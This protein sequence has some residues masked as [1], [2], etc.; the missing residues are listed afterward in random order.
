MEKLYQIYLKGRYDLIVLDTP[1]TR[2]ALDFLEA[3]NRVRTFFDRSISQWFLKPY[4]AMSKLGLNFFNRSAYV[5]LK[6]VERITGAEFLHDVSE[7]VTGLADAFD[8]FRSRAEEV[9]R[10]LQGESTSFLLITGTELA[11]IEEATF[12]YDQLR[13]GHLPFGGIIVN[14][15]HSFGQEYSGPSSY[16]DSVGGSGQ[17]PDPLPSF[18]EKERSLPPA[19][20]RG[21]T[22][23]CRHYRYL[24][25]RDRS[26]LMNFVNRFPENVPIRTI[27]AFDEDIYDLSGLLKVGAFLFEPG[28]P[29]AESEKL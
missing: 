29:Q 24:F 8:I 19:V 17:S 3:P 28:Q 25:E 22:D 15:V 6:M 9:M 5:V 11:A 20:V 16:A 13:K 14:R 12:F 2:H 26:I 21:L 10:L 4:L 18:L 7:F 1:P 27:P 23:N